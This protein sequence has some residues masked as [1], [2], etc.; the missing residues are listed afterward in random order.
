MKK[1]MLLG[2]RHLGSWLPQK[3]ILEVLQTCYH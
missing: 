2:L 1:K 3:Y